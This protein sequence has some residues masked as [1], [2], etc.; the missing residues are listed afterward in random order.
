MMGLN[1]R[2][3]KVSMLEISFVRLRLSGLIFGLSNGDT[4]NEN[5]HFTF[6]QD[7]EKH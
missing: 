3:K 1:R 2:A 7:R 5:I 6:P 4:L